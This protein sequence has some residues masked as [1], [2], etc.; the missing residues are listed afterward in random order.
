M[1]IEIIGDRDFIRSAQENEGVWVLLAGQALYALP[2][3][4]GKALPVWLSA[5]D[6][7]SFARN[8]SSDGLSPVFVPMKAFLGAA[9]LESASQQIIDV[10]AS[11]RYGHDALT[12]T[13]DEL[14]AKLKT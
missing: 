10:L 9:W 6:A 11:P 13:A 5:A 14:R 7:E 12:Y 3:D 1:N 8:L 4:G 2:V